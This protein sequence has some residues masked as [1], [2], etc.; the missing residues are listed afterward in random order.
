M[1][2]LHGQAP[3]VRSPLYRRLPRVHWENDSLLMKIN[4]FFQQGLHDINLDFILT[5]N[6]N[7]ASLIL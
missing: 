7:R 4:P 3:S 2:L 5:F 6:I 1:G